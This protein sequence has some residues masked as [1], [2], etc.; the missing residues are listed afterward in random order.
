MSVVGEAVDNEAPVMKLE[1]VPM[2]VDPAPSSKI[3][4]VSPG[5]QTVDAALLI[6]SS[7]DTVQHHFLLNN[8]ST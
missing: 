5:K 8:K 4:G 2:D 7:T 1:S 3:A 6:I